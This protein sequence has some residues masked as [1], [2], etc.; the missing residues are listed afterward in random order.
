[1]D[2]LSAR[3]LVTK[4]TQSAILDIEGEYKKRTENLGGRVISIKQGLDAGINIFDI[5]VEQEENGMEKINILNKVAEIRAILSGII[6]SYMDRP[7]N[8][9]ELVD[10]E[11]SVIET[12]KAKGITTFKESLYEKEG[13]KIG[14][15]LTL[16]KIKKEMP[17]LTDFQ[18]ILA[19]K[20]NSKELAE[21]LT[22]F[23]RGKSLGM[24]DCQSN[25]NINDICIDFDL[26]N[27]TD[28][29]T[30]FYA[31]LVI[32]T[33]I[34]EK[35]MRRSSLYEEK[36]IYIDEAW[37]MLKYEETA[38]EAKDSLMRLFFGAVSIGVAPLFVKFLLLLNNNL[39][40]MIV[41]YANGSLDELLGNSVITNIQTG[42][43]IA[44]AIVIALFAYLFFKLNVKFI[45]RQFTILIFTLFTPIIA[46]MW[47]INKRAIGATIWFGQI[48]IN[49][50]MQFIYAFLFLVYMQFLPQ[51]GGWATS[52]LWAMM[53]L[54]INNFKGRR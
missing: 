12:Y 15:K 18:K 19:S 47:M 3:S 10:I 31:S 25:I 54:P 1:M 13:G 2:T 49:I 45:I 11:E 30:K 17:T 51:S 24:F 34:T 6:K 50:F 28:E 27:I 53:I 48:L 16:G 32:T 36:S 46:I 38:N 33:W 41:G 22:G 7:L 39:V 9:K 35:Y 26:S 5:D 43:A 8:A 21:I 20:K 37:T 29:V 44:T 14:N 52:I 42:N 40:H 23:L 4:N